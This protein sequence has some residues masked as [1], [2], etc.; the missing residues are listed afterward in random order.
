[1][2]LFLVLFLACLLV[3]LLLPWWSIT[4][5]CLMGGYA[6]GR[7]GAGAF[8]GGFAAV[9]AGW[10]LAALVP[11]VLTHSTLPDRVATLLKLPGGG[12]VLLVVAA[13][14]GGLI[15]GLATLSG[16]WLRVTGGRGTTESGFT[17]GQNTTAD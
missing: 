6:L 17:N 1:M 9:T 10:A 5:V 12:P 7:S 14:L 16:W 3:Q 2:R 15:G 11:W 8:G 13:V 4:L